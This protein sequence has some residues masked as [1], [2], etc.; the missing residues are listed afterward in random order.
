TPKQ[1]YC[2]RNGCSLPINVDL[3]RNTRHGYCSIGCA[4]ACGENPR[5]VPLSALAPA[6]ASTSASVSAS[7]FAYAPTSVPAPSPARTGFEMDLKN[8]LAQ[9]S[10]PLPPLPRSAAERQYLTPPDTEMSSP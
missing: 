1:I 9:E 2:R 6:P 7:V 10:K 3:V 5:V 8:R 4:R